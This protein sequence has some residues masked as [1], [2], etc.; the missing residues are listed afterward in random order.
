MNGRLT[1]HANL[2]HSQPTDGKDLRFHKVGGLC[3]HV[4]RLADGNSVNDLAFL[5][6]REN[7]SAVMEVYLYQAT[8]LVN[9]R[10]MTICQGFRKN[11]HE[12]MDG[13][14]MGTH[15]IASLRSVS[16]NTRQ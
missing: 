7:T 15:T 9:V 12:V 5:R 13:N 10:H 6:N 11:V 16:H 3:L 2:R 1:P 4:F 8:Q 14:F